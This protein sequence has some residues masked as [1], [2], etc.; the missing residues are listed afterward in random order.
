MRCHIAAAYTSSVL[1][2]SSPPRRERLR[3]AQRR[4][5]RRLL[6]ARAFRRL[7]RR[8]VQRPLEPKDHP[9]AR[10]RTTSRHK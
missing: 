4:E 3:F 8:R 9:R 6:S 1:L 7:R 2:P 5:Q 10:G